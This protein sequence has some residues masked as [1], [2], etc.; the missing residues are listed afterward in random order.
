MVI[1]FSGGLGIPKRQTGVQPAG[2]LP[3][4]TTFPMFLMVSVKFDSC[5]SGCLRFISKDLSLSLTWSTGETGPEG[6]SCPEAVVLFERVVVARPCVPR[7]WCM[8]FSL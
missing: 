5:S 6:A 3:C 8:R 7:S 2:I 1:I 4:E